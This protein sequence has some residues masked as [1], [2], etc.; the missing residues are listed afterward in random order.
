M[1]IRAGLL[2]RLAV[3]VA[4]VLA[5]VSPGQSSARAGARPSVRFHPRFRVVAGPNQLAMADGRYA[6]IAQESFRDGGTLIDQATG[7]ATRFTPPP[8]CG[9][10]PVINPLGGPWALAGCG[11]IYEDSYELYDVSAGTWR[12]LTP[13][14]AALEAGNAGCS[15]N[16]SACSIA[17]VA[18][19]AQ[20]IE[21]SI[22]WNNDPQAPPPTYGAQNISSGRVRHLPPQS[23][24]SG[25][26]VLDLN[27]PQLTQPL[28]RPVTVAPN[29]SFLP[30]TATIEGPFVISTGVVNSGWAQPVQNGH[31][32]IQRCGS[33]RRLEI[34]PQN[35]PLAANAHAVLWDTSNTSATMTGLLLPS[36][37]QFTVTAPSLDVFPT[38]ADRTLYFDNQARA[39]WSTTSPFPP[40][41]YGSRPAH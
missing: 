23:L 25:N 9:I 39:I 18:V 30:G 6:L 41:T 38:L 3:F 26:R 37:R 7:V 13:N 21:F 34:D 40:H 12:P 22:T 17:P 16:T 2:T 15:P 32:Y 8:D 36:L 31:V 11:K 20:W 24:T 10:A 4:L 14:V 33:K 29:K 19:G 1:I 27:S 28:C 5:A 35:L